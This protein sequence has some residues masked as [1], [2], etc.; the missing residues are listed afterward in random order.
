MLFRSLGIEENPFSV[1]N[2][3]YI[4]VGLIQGEGYGYIV[5]GSNCIGY[6]EDVDSIATH[7]LREGVITAPDIL[8]VDDAWRWGAEML[9]ASKDPIVKAKISNI[10][11]DK[12]KTK[13]DS[14]GKIRVTAREGSEYEFKIEKVGYSISSSGI[15]G[16]MELEA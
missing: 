14:T 7:G 1:R 8:D 3:L 16:Q 5:E 9:A 11:F 12:T 2:R 13:V 10:V 4:K 15:L 6:V